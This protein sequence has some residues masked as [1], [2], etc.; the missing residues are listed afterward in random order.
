[1]ERVLGLR[2]DERATV[3]LASAVAGIGAA[4]LTIAASS[5]D[6]LLFSHGGVD[7][8][9]WL[10]VLLGLTMFAASIGVAALL[11]RLGRGRAFLLVPAAI[12]L[13]AGVARVALAAD[14]G[15]IYPTLWLVRGAAEFLVGLAVW[16]LAGLVTDTRQ[17]KRFFPLIGAAAVLGQVLGGLA[18]RPLA[19]WLGTEN[20]VLVWM[21]TLI[22][23]AILGGVL[24]GRADP[25][26]ARPRRR[27]APVL[28][29]LRDGARYALRSPLLRWMSVGSVLFSLL[30]F[31]LYLPFSRAAVER[32]PA[33]EDLAG[34]LGV[35]TAIATGVTL[36]L[37]LL[38]MNRLLSRVGVPTVMMVLPILY[39]VAFGVLTISATFAL[40][41]AFRFAQL[42]WLQGG[43][44][45]S[46]EAV[47]NTVPGDRRDRVRAFLYGGPTQVGTVLAGVV[48]LIGERAVSPRVLF[49]LGLVAAVAAVAT[50]L[51]VR[52]AY[53]AE[54]L[55]A[56]REGRPHVFGATPGGG[57]PFGHGRA[58]RT[59]AS[60]AIGGMSDPDVGVRRVAAQLLGDLDVPGG[61]EAL[62][63]ALDDEDA[64][65]RATALYSLGK[66]GAFG[67]AD[68]IPDRL[69]D[70]VPEVRLAALHALGSLRADSA[71]RARPLLADPDGIVRAHAAGILL[72]GGAVDGQGEAVLDRLT[73]SPYP[74][75]RAAAYEALASARS[76]DAAALARGGL[77]DPIP[78]VRAEAARAVLAT[79]PARGVDVLLA[80]IEQ[81]GDVLEAAHAAVGASPERA[82][83]PIRELAAASAAAALADRRL[84]DSIQVGDDDRLD[85][86]RDALL[87]SSRDRAIVALHAVALLGDHVRI[88]TALDSLA[89]ADPAQRANAL[90]VIETVADRDLVRPLIALWEPERIHHPDAEWRAE[91]L[92]HPDAR[93]RAMATWAVDRRPEDH[94]DEGGT[95]TETLTT[96]PMMERVLFL[97]RVPLFADLPP[98]DLLPIAEIAT[99]H[100]FADADTIAEQGEPGDEMHII[101]TGYVMVI[102][103]ES[104]GH[105]EVLAVR[106]AGDVIGEMAV[107]TGGARMASLAAKGDVR[108][109]SIERRQFESVL[110]ERPETALALMRILCE[111]LAALERG[112]AVP[113]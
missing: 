108:L 22:L 113:G 107:I 97:R 63:S 5:V 110:R 57:E 20:L 96:L 24:V 41:L 82:S 18:T 67:A 36:V 80:S 47:I 19:G 53:T 54:L 61:A 21:G 32:Y 104:D 69:S 15:W 103:R 39:L 49:A 8:L 29:D 75:A 99:E 33:P 10:Y 7:D 71:A 51:R 4:G 40:L 55:V 13:V 3:G 27:R 38:V 89:A 92:E 2:P 17:A 72:A 58:D 16:G 100:S 64:E 109:L 106:S 85:V 111:R 37:A 50:M 102:I 65:V 52:R 11:G 14:V 90:E 112:G 56:L 105:Q 34:F 88:D 45:T 83:P 84:A 26:A 35:F 44:S 60:V 31:S 42:V 93:I 48:T 81:G 98:H 87:A 43:A 91:V 70:P 62:T 76:P 1:M 28:E 101:V 59:A 68:G 78:S 25:A 12:A 74:E 46:W 30:F 66:I 94:P 77:R 23:V 79:D 9:P 95:M 6:A 73:R 86:L